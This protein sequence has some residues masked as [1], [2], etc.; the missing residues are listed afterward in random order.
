V[1]SKKQQLTSARIANTLATSGK[2]SK[3]TLSSNNQPAAGSSGVG[4]QM[5]WATRG[6][7][8]VTAVHDMRICRFF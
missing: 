6:S 4:C 8:A 3:S 5:G 7:V 1:A 2:L